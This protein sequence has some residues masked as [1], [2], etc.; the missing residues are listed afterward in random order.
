MK[1]KNKIFIFS[2]LIF[3]LSISAASAHENMLADGNDAIN[4]DI[5]GI[6]DLDNDLSDL[7]DDLDDLDDDSDDWD[8]DDWD[9]W[10]DD[11]DDLDDD[12]DDWDGDDWDDWDD[13]F[14]DWDGDDWDDWDDDFDDWDDDGYW[15]DYYYDT[16]DWDDYGY[17]DE[18]D[19]GNRTGLIKLNFVTCK[20]LIAYKKVMANDI[21]HGSSCDD[22][23]ESADDYESADDFEETTGAHEKVS[24]MFGSLLNSPVEIAG[25][26]FDDYL[27]PVSKSIDQSQN[28][29]VEEKET[30]VNANGTDCDAITTSSEDNEWDILSLL[31]S[32]LFSIILAI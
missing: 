29:L 8:G 10:D 5:I 21:A 14:D 1:F 24:V 32:L 11:L 3:M 4:N 31:V 30:S 7:D 23:N 27:K 15:Y 17:G 9:D 26:S 16:A 22:E 12:S 2:L 19:S 28:F 13:D 6:G 25:L 20:P 18:N